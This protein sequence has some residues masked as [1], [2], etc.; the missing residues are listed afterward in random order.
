MWTCPSGILRARDVRWRCIRA[1]NDRY[2][3][4]AK[5]PGV[6][7][8]DPNSW[9]EFGDFGRDGLHLNRRGTR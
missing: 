4:V 2:N 9:I 1:V 6:T 3:W 7:F 8:L 5:N